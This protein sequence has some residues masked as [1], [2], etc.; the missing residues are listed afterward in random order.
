MTGVRCDRHHCFS[1]F[2][3][4]IG[5]HRPTRAEEIRDS[6]SGRGINAVNDAPLLPSRGEM[7]LGAKR[8]PHLRQG[9]SRCGSTDVMRGEA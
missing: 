7:I 4:G 6:G 3:A 9:S 2:G 1:P 5:R 8:P